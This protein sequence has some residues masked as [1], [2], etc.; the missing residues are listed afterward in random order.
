MEMSDSIGKWEGVLDTR[1]FE[2]S[3]D[4]RNREQNNVALITG[5]ADYDVVRVGNG[6]RQWL[7]LMVVCVIRGVVVVHAH[8]VNLSA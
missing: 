4:P 7:T 8:L 2:L 3:N 5:G 6:W 1:P